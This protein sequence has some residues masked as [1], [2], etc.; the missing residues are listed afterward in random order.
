MDY[1]QKL[2]V[3]IEI[4]SVEGIRECFENGISPNDLHN[5]KPLNLRTDQ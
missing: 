3:D 5:N 4:Q 1:L 2:I